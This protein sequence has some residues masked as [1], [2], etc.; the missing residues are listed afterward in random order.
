MSDPFVSGTSAI[1]DAAPAEYWRREVAAITTDARS[2]LK[3]VAEAQRIYRG[4]RLAVLISATESGAAVAGTTMSKE[5]A[6]ALAVMVNAV[7]G[8]MATEVSP[9][10]TIEDGLY[11]MWPTVVPTV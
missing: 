8:F 3:R 7:Q 9:G 1:G 11:A 10:F 6:E 2:I 4:N 5:Q